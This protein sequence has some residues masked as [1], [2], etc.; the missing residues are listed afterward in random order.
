M[1]AT[2]RLRTVKALLIVPHRDT[3]RVPADKLS[4]M[5]AE[6]GTQEEVAFALG[7]SRAS[8]ARYE[9]KGG[10]RAYY[11]ALLGLKLEVSRRRG[12]RQ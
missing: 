5:R 11:Y 10:P 9:A 8:V 1:P 6:L 2:S 12:P 7:I 3:K 4:A